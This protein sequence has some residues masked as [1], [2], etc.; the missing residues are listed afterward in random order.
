MLLAYLQTEVFG[1]HGSFQRLHYPL[2][3]RFGLATR[4]QIPPGTLAQQLPLA[5][6]TVG[7]DDRLPQSHC[8]QD[9]VWHAFM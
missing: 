7:R 8:L 4:G 6:G 2:G 3:E 1:V 5:P 9:R